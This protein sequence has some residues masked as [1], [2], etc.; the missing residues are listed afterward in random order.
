MTQ[1]KG[2]KM[3]K[4][5]MEGVVGLMLQEGETRDSNWPED[6]DPTSW[7]NEE[8]KMIEEKMMG[9]LGGKGK[10]AKT[11]IEYNNLGWMFHYTTT[12]ITEIAQ[13]E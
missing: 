7:T 11:K 8:S 3:N 2:H 5:W 4:I 10:C 6:R 13:G 1:L 9:W 12:R